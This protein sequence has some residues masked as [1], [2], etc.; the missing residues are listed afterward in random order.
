MVQSFESALEQISQNTKVMAEAMPGLV[1]S[2]NKL[3]KT[4]EKES[5]KDQEEKVSKERA[6]AD[7]AGK[8]KDKDLSSIDDSL[9]DIKKLLKKQGKEEGGILG[10]L[11]NSI[12]ALLGGGGKGKATGGFV[13]KSPIQTFQNGG[14]VYNVPGNSTGDNH[15]MLLPPGSF[16]LNREA[17]KYL[18]SGGSIPSLSDSPQRFNE[19]GMVPTK[20]ESGEM[21]FGPGNWDGLLP[22]LNSVIPRFQTGGLIE[23]V[24]G[25]P[26]RQ[27]TST[28]WYDKAGHGLESNAHD[29]FAFDSRETRDYVMGEL[30]KMGYQIGS[31]DRPGDTG[32]Y[33][34][35]GQAFDVPWSQ[36]GSGA[37]NE[38][39]YQQSQKLA[40]DVQSILSKRSGGGKEQTQP[41]AL[42]GLDLISKP[43]TQESVT[44]GV[45]IESIMG[46]ALSGGSPV[47]GPGIGNNDTG[48]GF[49]SPAT[50]GIGALLGFKTIDMA[51]IFGDVFGGIA[52]SIGALFGMGGED[53]PEE[54]DTQSSN[55]SDT[56]SS[57]D[58]T[59]GQASGAISPDKGVGSMGFS[60]ADWNVYRNTVAQIESGG[61]YDISGGSGN[62]YDGRYQLGAAAKTDGARYAGI[63]DP[64]HNSQAREAFRKNPELQEQ[65]FTGFTK[66]N[67][68]YLMRIPEYR[69]AN[70]QRKLQI[71]GYA[72]NQG[73]GGAEQWMKTG[74]VGKDG[75][76]TKGTKYTDSIAAEFK[77]RQQKKQMGGDITSPF[78]GNPLGLEPVKVES[79]E[80]IFAPGSYGPEIIQ[81]NDAIPRFQT[82]G[83]VGMAV[84]HIKK[85]EALSSLTAGTNDWIRPG[86]SS[87]KSRKPWSDINGGTKLHAYLDSVGV[88]TIGWGNT[89]YDSIRNGK[90]PVKMGDTVTKNKADDIMNTN[91]AALASDYSKEIPRWNKMSNDQKAG[92]I[93]MGYNA[94][95]FYSSDTFA[96]KLKKA[97]QSGDTHAI[98]ENLS[99][100]GPSQTRINESQAMMKKG[101]KDLSQHKI[102]GK[103]NA[104]MPS[105]PPG[106]F[107]SKSGGGNLFDRA[108]S[109]LGFQTGGMVGGKPYQRGG[110]INNVRNTT[111]PIQQLFQSANETKMQQENQNNQ[112]III[113]IP[114][115]MQGPQQ[116]NNGHPDNTSG[117]TTPSLPNSPSNHIV[118]TLMMQTYA[119]MNNIG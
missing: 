31:V 1:A 54:S 52:K 85:D 117:S 29:H 93:S 18:Q 15:S 39:D 84:D 96:P 79:G 58:G 80:K 43:E 74:K 73:M 113:P 14:E 116:V 99:W 106:Q 24:H 34:S 30:K 46:G 92:L 77:K 67:H 56:Q 50:T 81:L 66:A 71:L 57:K 108:K 89:Y 21:I 95:N 69:D 19:G 72:H 48:G 76:G 27:N 8:S 61:K 5:K 65:L 112:P 44:P 102:T 33:H 32:S 37:I 4:E 16:V 45:N 60:T 38:K 94:P 59:G 11:G 91:V 12:K 104:T 110:S 68:T 98:A 20:V 51:G 53:S 40:K 3:Y 111:N 101:P 78:G 87:V 35:T 22:I 70:P 36:F 2:V 10:M 83:A 64:G 100:G 103:T 97:I 25:D 86:G 115:Q 26:T 17:S 23:H 88:A 41:T 109:M 55:E 119:L 114:Q 105:N 62:H 42:S 7:R 82:G 13:Y 49:T 75:F 118:S 6:K 9:K 107:K 63:D 28:S 90:K 47:Q